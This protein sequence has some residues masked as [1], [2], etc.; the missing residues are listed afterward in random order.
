M[1]GFN[2]KVVITYWYRIR[3]GEEFMKKIVF[4]FL[5]IIFLTGCEKVDNLKEVYDVTK[6]VKDVIQ[7][8]LGDTINVCQIYY[9]NYTST[10]ADEQYK[11][12]MSGLDSL[13]EKIGELDKL[14]KVNS[15]K[16]LSAK[17]KEMRKKSS[18][19]VKDMKKYYKVLYSLD[20]VNH[21]NISNLSSK[22]LE[23]IKKGTDIYR[24]LAKKLSIGWY[25]E[26]YKIYATAEKEL[27]FDE[28][29]KAVEE[30]CRGDEEQ[31]CSF[32]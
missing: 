32:E 24:R 20:T 18:T 21:E 17:W 8:N 2:R 16:S 29:L 9:D 31:K 15:D 5:C 25:N 7:T 19:V 3:I 11:S 14:M 13:E 6:E 12:C 1:G 28:F 26:Y 4:M 23:D 30:A 22:D 10:S 27:K